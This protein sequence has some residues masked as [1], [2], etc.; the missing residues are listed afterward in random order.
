MAAVKKN[1][2]WVVG[3]NDVGQATL[4]WSVDPA[5]REAEGDPFE[6][7]HDFLCRLDADLS[8]ERDSAPPRTSDPYNS[9]GFN[10]RRARVKR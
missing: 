10:G 1:S 5:A 7:T 8:L 3:T 9:T 6:R 2:E 4:M